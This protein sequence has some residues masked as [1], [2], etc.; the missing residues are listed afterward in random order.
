MQQNVLTT[1]IWL[2]STKIRVYNDFTMK[3]DVVN[4]NDNN[5]LNADADGSS[6]NY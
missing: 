4:N 1:Y 6:N 2:I 3:K 5:S